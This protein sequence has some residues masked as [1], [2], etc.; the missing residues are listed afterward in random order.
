MYQELRDLFSKSKVFEYFECSKISLG[1]DINMSTLREDPIAKFIVF[2]YEFLDPKDLKAHSRTGLTEIV[3]V[4]SSKLRYPL[5]ELFSTL[6]DLAPKLVE[7]NGAHCPTGSINCPKWTTMRLVDINAILQY[8]RTIIVHNILDPFD[9]V[10]VVYIGKRSQKITKAHWHNWLMF[11]K[12][13][14]IKF[15]DNVVKMWKSIPDSKIPSMIDLSSRI[16]VEWAMRN[17]VPVSD[18]YNTHYKPYLPDNYFKKVLFPQRS[19]VDIQQV[20]LAPSSRYSVT[21]PDQ[22][23]QI[24]K[25]AFDL[26]PAKN[27][28][29]AIITDATANVGGNTIAFAKYF[30][31]VN[32]V[33]IDSDVAEC[34]QSNIRLYGHGNSVKV[35]ISDYTKVYK[36]LQQDVVFMDPPWGGLLYKYQPR[37]SLT[38]GS[39]DIFDIIQDLKVPIV[40]KAP[41]NAVIK[42]KPDRTYDISN[43]KLHIFRK[44]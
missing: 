42:I 8:D 22:A 13:E 20:K 44:R 23:E 29:K 36:D 30:S 26:I 3:P 19:G 33:E 32:S 9:K 18:Y 6:P 35:I 38:L 24:A 10:Y 43:Y 28:S 7:L 31:K 41:S 2:P 39:V 40:L 21:P 27:R 34:L 37:I 12:S 15:K 5:I 1:S 11:C 14:V 25:I 17:N 16:S 4:A